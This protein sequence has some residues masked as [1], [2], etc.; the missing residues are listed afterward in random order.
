MDGGN[1]YDPKRWERCTWG[2]AAPIKNASCFRQA[3]YISATRD[4]SH[5][6]LQHGITKLTN[7]RVLRSPSSVAFNEERSR[8]GRCEKEEGMLLDGFGY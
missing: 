8:A 1:K 2:G 5:P 4:I 7:D 6:K 3:S